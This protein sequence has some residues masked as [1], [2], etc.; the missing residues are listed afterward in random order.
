MSL[1]TKEKVDK[2]E[3]AV[4]LLR[5]LAPDIVGRAEDMLYDAGF[6]SAAPGTEDR[7]VEVFIAMFNPGG[8]FAWATGV[9]KLGKFY[10]RFDRNDAHYIW[11]G[12][13]GEA[14]YF[15]YSLDGATEVVDDRR[16]A[17]ESEADQA[18][19]DMIRI[20]K[21]SADAYFTVHRA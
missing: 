9:P 3:K 13:A 11:Y 16:F 20:L 12:P 4:R 18:G 8:W 2:H 14:W 6:S 10:K 1:L 5:E 19:R 7:A 15:K 17:S 21:Q